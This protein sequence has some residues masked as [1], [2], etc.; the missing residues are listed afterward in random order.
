MIPDIF[1]EVKAEVDV[2]RG[3]DLDHYHF[4]SN[5]MLLANNFVVSGDDTAILIGDVIH[6][7]DFAVKIRR[8]K[9]LNGYTLFETSKV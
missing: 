6:F 2:I 5:V 7:G 3:N 4:K 9:K 8:S 1:S